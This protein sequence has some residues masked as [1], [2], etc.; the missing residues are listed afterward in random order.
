MNTSEVIMI[1]SQRMGRSQ[2]ETHKTLTA[3][4]DKLTDVLAAD[5]GFTIPGFG[6][7]ITRWRRARRAYNPASK[8]IVWLPSVKTVHFRS[9]LALKQKISEVKSNK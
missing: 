3:T 6:T 5:T 9:A 8:A 2:R 7:L 4:V 1:L